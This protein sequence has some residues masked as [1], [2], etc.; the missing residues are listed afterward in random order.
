[1]KKYKNGMKF[2]TVDTPESINFELPL[3]HF[4]MVP[5]LNKVK[6]KNVLNKYVCFV[7]WNKAD[8]KG[9]YPRGEKDELEVN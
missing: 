4:D 1:L 7:K 6:V 9:F 5:A 8:L 2:G 3:D